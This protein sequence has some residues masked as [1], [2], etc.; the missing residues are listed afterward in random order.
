MVRSSNPKTIFGDI[1]RSLERAIDT[2]F[3]DINRDARDITPIRTGR[4]RAGWRKASKYRIGDSGVIVENPVSY[5]GVLDRGSSRQAPQGIVQPV[6]NNLL[7]R[8]TR[9]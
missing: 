4:A 1:E 2:L 7:R 8:R 6:L 5:I 9:L 3:S